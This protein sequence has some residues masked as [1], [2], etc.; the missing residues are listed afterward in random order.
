V[1]TRDA[2]VPASAVVVVAHPD[3]CEFACGATVVRW[4]R[5]GA[6]AD[7]VV[8]TD[9]TKGSH[10]PELEAQDLARV[11]QEEQLL[12]ARSLGFESVV[13]L[14][15][16]DG[17]SAVTEE[18]LRELA[19]LLRRFRPEVVVTHDPWRPYELHPDHVVAG[20]AGCEAVFRAREPRFYPEAPV[21]EPRL[22][23]ELWL[24]HPAEPNHVEHS[25]E[26]LDSVAEALACHRSQFR[27]SL[28]IDPSDPDVRV[29]VEAFVRRRYESDG[30]ERFRRIWL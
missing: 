26:T 4:T 11:R 15:Q 27:T 12:A 8:V 24:F 20:R 25:H 17:E 9:G 29:A 23:G 18:L 30:G 6:R 2:A 13:F 16:V 21:A 7:L 19:L 14:G 22:P 3:D 28:G 5:A 1:T 10:D